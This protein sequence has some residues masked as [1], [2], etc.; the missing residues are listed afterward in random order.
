MMVFRIPSDMVAKIK[1]WCRCNIGEGG[2]WLGIDDI[3]L[4]DKWGYVIK[5]YK[6][7]IVIADNNDGVRFQKVWIQADAFA[8]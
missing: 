5:N 4:D 6:S 8:S 2:T 3:F 1:T 7:Y